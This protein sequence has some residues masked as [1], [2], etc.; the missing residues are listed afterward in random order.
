[1]HCGSG[2]V[3][4]GCF[5]MEDI[6]IREFIGNGN[7][8]GNGNGYGN[9]NGNGTGNGSG[10]G[11]GSGTGY[12]DGYGDGYGS[13]TGTGY[14]DGYGCGGSG[15]GIETINGKKIYQ[16]DDIETLI[17]H[18]HGNIARGHILNSDLTTVPCY[19]I[20]QNGLYAH[21]TKLREAQAALMEKLFEDM[22]EEER[23]SE[24]IQNHQDKKKNYSNA[25]L[26]EW[27]NRLTGSCL[28]GRQTF[29]KN[30]NISLDD[31]M[32]V[33]EFIRLTQNEYGKEIIW[34]LL[35]YY[36]I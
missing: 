20:K 15:S 10:D 4:K 6:R 16:I 29:C 11:S 14:G 21:G 2:S 24:F 31:N 23:I 34:K 12:G 17:D 25:D 13:G 19:V 3:Y 8:N 36:T 32:T 7:G 33:Q 27:H 30:H 26:F 28:M 35:P 22:P 9:G 5:G 1:M 18:V